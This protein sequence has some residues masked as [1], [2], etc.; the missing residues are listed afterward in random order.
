LWGE[1]GCSSYFILGKLDIADPKSLTAELDALR[2]RLLADP[3]FRGVPSMQPDQRKTAV[4]FHAKDDLSEVRREVFG[5]LLKHQVDFYA[6]VREK[7]V[8]SKG[9]RTQPETVDVPLSPQS[10][11][12]QMR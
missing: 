11:I 8:I 5:V 2:A 7:Q 1:E 6:V 4:A 3:Y 10:A 12:R 9:A